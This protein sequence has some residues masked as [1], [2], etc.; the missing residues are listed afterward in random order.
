[1]CLIE[2][3]YTNYFVPI[4]ATL[5]ILVFGY[6]PSINSCHD[7]DVLLLENILTSLLS[8]SEE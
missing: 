2:N 6:S 1:M 3:V 4:K 8:V 5:P 7:D